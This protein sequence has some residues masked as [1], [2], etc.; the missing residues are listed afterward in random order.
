M[1]DR[2]I[3][4]FANVTIDDGKIYG[5]TLSYHFQVKISESE[6]PAVCPQVN[7]DGMPVEVL[8]KKAWDAMKVSGRPSM[9]K[10]NAKELEDSYNHQDINWQ[11][12]VSQEAANSYLNTSSMSDDQLER[13]I[14]RLQNLRNK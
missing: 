12:M 1:S 10:L 13:E 7:C 14:Q 2:K 9:K 3:N 5:L 8:C 6:N 11:V 4:D